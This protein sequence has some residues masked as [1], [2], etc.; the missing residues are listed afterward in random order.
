MRVVLDEI[1]A[2]TAVGRPG[3]AD[4]LANAA[5]NYEPFPGINRASSTALCVLH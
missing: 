4:A 2:M 5:P 1:E 3:H